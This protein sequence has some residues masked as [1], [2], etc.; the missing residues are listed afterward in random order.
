MAAN[1]LEQIYL[2]YHKD[3][4]RWAGAFFPDISDRE[5]AVSEAFLRLMPHAEQVELVNSPETAKL[6]QIIL[7]NVSI[8][9]L[10]KRSR[11]IPADFGEAQYRHRLDEEALRA[12]EENDRDY[13]SLYRAVERLPEET[14]EILWLS[15][16]Y[17]FTAR[18]IGR[19]YGKS[20]PAVHKILSR[21]RKQL[22][23]FL[24]EKANEENQ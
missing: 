23:E 21:A 17:R 16:K 9:I 22:K 10:R 3:M 12:H 20:V 24:E 4:L 7:K 1:K 13:E 5:D 19:Q 6:C 15:Y 14:R 11:E 18:E 8:N 2:R